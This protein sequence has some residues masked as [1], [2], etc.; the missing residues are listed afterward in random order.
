[1]AVLGA[2]MVRYG[3]AYDGRA[4][5]CTGA[6]AAGFRP[7]LRRRRARAVVARVSG[8]SAVARGSTIRPLT[9]SGRRRREEPAASGT[10]PIPAVPLRTRPPS[11]TATSAPRGTKRTGST[12]ALEAK[13]KKQRRQQPKKV[14]EQA[15]VPIKFAQGGGSRQAPRVAS[16]PPRQRREPTPQ[17]SSRAPTP[18]PPAGTA[19]SAGASSFAVPLASAPDR[20]TRVEPPRQ[21]TLDD[22]F[23]RRAPFVERAAGAGRGMP[24]V[25]GAGAGA[26]LVG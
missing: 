2:L 8:A 7:C 15:G 20:G 22:M 17:P 3:E 1:M 26:V 19:P 13:A 6:D 24:S 16:P 4:M 25:A 5:A 21:P 11:T 12:A 10:G 18:P 23:P 14:P 9:E